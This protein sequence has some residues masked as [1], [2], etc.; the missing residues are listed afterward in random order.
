M[1]SRKIKMPAA[2]AKR[3]EKVLSTSK[4]IRQ[5][6][7]GVI[8]IDT[9]QA[10]Q[11]TNL[12]GKKLEDAISAFRTLYQMKL[13]E[14]DDPNK[15]VDIASVFREM[16][17]ANI[18][19]K[20]V[21]IV[22][23][24][25]V[26]KEV[27]MM[28]ENR[29][30]L[31]NGEVLTIEN[32]YL[33]KEEL[34]Q[35]TLAAFLYAKENP[36]ATSEEIIL[37]VDRKTKHLIPKGQKDNV[38][39]DE[40]GTTTIEPGVET[41]EI[42]VSTIKVVDEIADSEYI[43]YEKAK[44]F[45]RYRALGNLLAIHNSP[46]SMELLES[47][48]KP[49]RFQV[50]QES[51]N[52]MGPRMDQD[53]QNL[54]KVIGDKRY[55][56]GLNTRNE[57]FRDYSNGNIACD[58]IRPYQQ[59]NRKI[60]P[61]ERENDD[62]E[63]END[64]EKKPGRRSI[65]FLKTDENIKM[66]NFESEALEFTDSPVPHL[67]YFVDTVMEALSFMTSN[68]DITT[69]EKYSFEHASNY[70]LPLSKYIRNNMKNF[71]KDDFEVV[72]DKSGE[73]AYS[74]FQ[75]LFQNYSRMTL[76]EKMASLD[77][78]TWIII[79]NLKRRFAG[80]NT[81][82]FDKLEID[83]IRDTEGSVLVD[84]KIYGGVYDALDMIPNKTTLEV[85]LFNYFKR[86]YG[87]ISSAYDELVTIREPIIER[88]IIQSYVDYDD[89]G[90]PI[91]RQERII[92]PAWDVYQN[93][94]KKI[95]IRSGDGVVE[96]DNPEYLEF[97]QDYK[98]KTTQRNI[99]GAMYYKY[100]AYAKQNPNESLNLNDDSFDNIVFGWI[101]SFVTNTITDSK[102]GYE[103]EMYNFLTYKSLKN[104]KE[105][106]YDEMKEK[107]EQ[108]VM[109]VRLENDDVDIALSQYALTPK[110]RLMKDKLLALPNISDDESQKLVNYMKREKMHQEEREVMRE[111]IGDLDDNSSDDEE[112]E[113]DLRLLMEEEESDDE[114][115]TVYEDG[116]DGRLTTDN[117]EFTI[118]EKEEWRKHDLRF[119]VTEFVKSL[120]VED[121]TLK[122]FVPIL[123]KLLAFVRI[124][125]REKILGKYTKYLR[126]SLK[127][128][129]MS[130]SDVITTDYAKLVPELYLNDKLSYDWINKFIEYS[131]GGEINNMMN[132][133]SMSQS[134]RNPRL[135]W[136][137][138]NDSIF[139]QRYKVEIDIQEFL[140]EA[141]RVFGMSKNEAY[142]Y[143]RSNVHSTTFDIEQVKYSSTNSKY[144]IN[145]KNG[146][147]VVDPK[148]TEYFIDDGYVISRKDRKFHQEFQ[149]SIQFE[150]DEFERVQSINLEN[151]AVSLSN[152]C[153]ADENNRVFVFDETR[154]L[155]CMTRA[156]AMEKIDI[157]E[158]Y[159][160]ENMR[161][162]LE[163]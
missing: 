104:L 47:T 135:E 59:K 123:C 150:A 96:I 134:G 25:V 89:D 116:E 82:A 38:V 71:T 41:E 16:N 22:N 107:W 18:K 51:L 28:G 101:R 98:I 146:R 129:Q 140:D 65:E 121:D 80:L 17:M 158:K 21:R 5:G 84:S 152:V 43:F 66:M 119:T 77:G 81:F 2:F 145:A 162:I 79:W 148:E 15:K 74:K 132:T 34:K 88:K 63:S 30:V 138:V 37:H 87:K 56:L 141:E 73:N 70:I 36:E 155:V 131:I 127:M 133:L 147:V 14:L 27:Q 159:N 136:I 8:L 90:E 31:R 35:V 161:N 13:E 142:E 53:Y 58:K 93:L 44:M 160:S 39:V 86:N 109:K 139:G 62:E 100:R 115:D 76:N 52:L 72:P 122:R 156:K 153:S 94:P 99:S 117:I 12:K 46:D 91:S 97:I 95:T 154:K 50:I 106:V 55:N 11:I 33:K 20:K 32:K 124:S 57:Y 113:I 83:E 112:S 19:W 23:N 120:F 143:T 108:Y 4:A 45:Q 128:S 137:K 6:R 3:K 29:M 85:S 49:E 67:S 64:D 105:Q 7:Y 114:D 151:I 110:E 102:P 149:Q 26:S 157:L 75:E 163:R 42:E 111:R 144:Y 78:I 61:L 54:G 130:L 126:K 24:N 40:N 9:D 48:L 103:D 125:E 69:E 68:D 1:P 92:N 10:I 118:N 60:I